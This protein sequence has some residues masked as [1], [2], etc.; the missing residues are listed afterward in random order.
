MN[1]IQII[2]NSITLLL[3][4]YIALK[5]RTPRVRNA[6]NKPL[7]L[8]SSALIDGRILDVAKSGFLPGPVLVPSSVLRE[9]QYLADNGDHEKRARARNGLDMVKSLQ[10]I[11]GLTVKLINDGLPV[12]G[13]VDE[14]LVVLSKKYSAQLV[15]L[16]F[17][18]N[19]V[20]Q[21]E[22]IRVLN[23]NQLAQQLRMS[24]LPG[25]KRDITLVQK[26]QDKTQA[27]G[28]LEDGTMVVVE[29]MAKAIGTSVE[30]EFTRAIQTQSGR[31]LF[32]KSTTK[33][34]DSKIKTVEKVDTHQKPQRKLPT[35]RSRKQKRTPEDSLVE[36]ANKQ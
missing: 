35:S 31:M 21:A 3:V 10:E 25:E 17:N 5:G 30:V 22:G 1:T 9:M 34:Q 28:Y 2:I 13:G 19:K 18:L 14:R 8:D 24:Y 12:E 6:Q 32:A 26:G 7:L 15:T 33:P 20:A 4:V 36:L 16:D 29:N 27:V 23:I 11:D